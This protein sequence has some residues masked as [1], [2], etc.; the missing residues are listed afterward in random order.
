MGKQVFVGNID[1]SATDDDIRQAFE[2]S[3]L[4]VHTVRLMREED[5]GRSRG[6]AFVTLGESTDPET[7]I[8]HMT[9]IDVC[10]RPIRVDYVKEVKS[11][12]AR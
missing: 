5:T 10:G 3:R 9:G 2:A 1:W 8:E 4:D 6:F 7:A 12:T 11:R